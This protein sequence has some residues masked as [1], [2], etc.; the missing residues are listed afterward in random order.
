MPETSAPKRETRLLEGSTP[1]QP[2]IARRP[3]ETV[4]ERQAIA[5]KQRMIA[6]PRRE[7]ASCLLESAASL[8]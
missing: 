2:P 7:T 4:K 8:L 6:E 1:Q 3:C 5:G